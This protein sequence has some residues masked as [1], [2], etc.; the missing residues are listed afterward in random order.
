MHCYKLPLLTVL[1][2]IFVNV[3]DYVDVLSQPYKVCISLFCDVSVKAGVVDGGCV[4]GG[5]ACL[6]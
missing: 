1:V 3:F 6:F 2:C 5:V 4:C